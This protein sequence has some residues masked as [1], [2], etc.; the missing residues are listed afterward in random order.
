LGE[1]LDWSIF[2]A[3]GEEP[4][5]TI[6]SVSRSSDPAQGDISHRIQATHGSS[7]KIEADAKSDKQER[8]GVE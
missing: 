5:R 1:T 8:D 6:C 7:W 3:F 2:C 4:V